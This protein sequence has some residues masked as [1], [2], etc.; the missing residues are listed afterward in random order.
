[1]Y[2]PRVSSGLQVAIRMN[3]V[4]WNPLKIKNNHKKTV[5]IR[6]NYVSWNIYCTR[7][8]V[9]FHVVIR[10]NYVSWN[11]ELFRIRSIITVAICRN[12]VSWNFRIPVKE[13]LLNML[14]FV[15]IMWVEIWKN[16]LVAFLCVLQFVGIV[17]VGILEKHRIWLGWRVA[18]RRNRV[19]WN[20]IRYT[21]TTRRS[22]CDL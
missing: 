17:W 19:S 6:R 20:Y 13:C 1:M 21:K 3:C 14:Q 22:G 5:A 15:R 4:S 9:F 18:I 2:L 10:R 11:T 8:V 7:Y 12:Y 16:L